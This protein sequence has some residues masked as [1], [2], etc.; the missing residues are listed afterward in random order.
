[1]LGLVGEEPSW[2][3]RVGALSQGWHLPRVDCARLHPAC[4]VLRAYSV[5]I[6]GQMHSTR[7]TTQTFISRGG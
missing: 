6:R 2:P 7:E 5:G 3:W 1:M 4:P